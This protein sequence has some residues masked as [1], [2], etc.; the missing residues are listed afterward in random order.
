MRRRALI[1]LAILLAV[2][3]TVPGLAWLAWP[4]LLP[5]IGQQISERAGLERLELEADRPTLSGWRISR[6]AA[7]APS[8]LLTGDDIEI[9]WRAGEL[10]RGQVDA[11]AAARVWI[12]KRSVPAEAD[13]AGL[14]L[15]DVAAQLDTLPVGSLRIDDLAVRVP[16]Q[17]LLLRGHA[18]F[19]DK[20]MSLSLASVESPLA[21]P[22]RV[23]ASL[24]PAGSFAADVLTRMETDVPALRARGQ[25]DALGLT[26]QYDYELK[27][28]ELALLAGVLEWPVPA[29]SVTGAGTVQLDPAM[30]LLGAE[31]HSRLTL[32][33]AT[34]ARRIGP[35][36]L[37][38]DITFA[39]GVDGA[40][41][42]VTLAVHAPESDGFRLDATATGQDTRLAVRGTVA[43][44]E[45]SVAL[46]AGYFGR[47]GIT[48]R[49]SFEFAANGDWT[50]LEDN[51]SIDVSGPASLMVDGTTALQA[52]PLR[53][54]HDAA[55][56]PAWQV[57]ATQFSA[58]VTDEDS[59]TTWKT[60]A[61]A[62]VVT[63]GNEL[64]AS[65]RST[66]TLRWRDATDVYAFSDVFVEA[67]VNSQAGEA[68]V[69]ARL[70]YRGHTI[71]LQLQVPTAGNI[72]FS[73]S[74]HWQVTEPLLAPILEKKAA[75]DVVAGIIDAV[76]S[77]TVLPE[78]TELV[79]QGAFTG[80]DAVW[81][82]YVFKGLEGD[83][84]VH[85]PAADAWRVEMPALRV[86]SVDVGVAVTSV[87]SSVKLSE[88]I[89]S[90]GATG[91]D[92][93]GGTF[94][95][96]PFRYSF[97]DGGATLNVSLQGIDLGQVLALEG[98][99]L[100]GEGRLHASLPVTLVNDSPT[101][102]NGTLR[103]DGGG[104]IQLDPSL[105]RR[106]S[107]PGLDFALQALED[108]HYESLEADISYAESG[109]MQAAIRLKGRNPAVEKG[110]PIHYN[111]N[112]GENLPTLLKSLRLQDQVNQQVE[113]RVQQGAKR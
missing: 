15:A 98:E 18:A 8:F 35:V 48:G 111:L 1:T 75:Y 39:A 59:L 81:D 51:L 34:E 22:L 112:I 56:S 105:T 4:L 92:L 11:V 72:R 49:G 40:D 94:S 80:M 6:L 64:T 24:D 87:Q 36:T 17:S 70:G 26:I 23:S 95:I 61:F 10:R 54:T 108:F 3:L 101:V 33:L 7:E 45:S 74:V 9:A 52:A 91:G 67:D 107:Q 28:P 21:V 5:V 110:R 109:D 69:A 62:M 68:A 63:P 78:G 104:L 46:I 88:D 30:S 85:A 73:S 16:A 65:F 93:L 19:A 43:C 76:V 77:G 90:M 103:S 99:D 102:T 12:E 41:D 31:L 79:V 47:P 84:R 57:E 60:P 37:S 44:P 89:V 25:A 53:V 97:A 86:K 2:P 100:H 71:P 29:G 106:V 38:A 96:P 82:E 42:R 27:D 113:R 14:G 83:Y 58:E 32:V 66:G 13:A 55:Q 50:A 20:T